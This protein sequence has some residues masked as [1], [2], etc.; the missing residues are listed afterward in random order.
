MK[1]TLWFAII[2]HIAVFSILSCN[3]EIK[4]KRE[5]ASWEYENTDWEN[6]GYASCAGNS[7]SPVN[8]PTLQTIISDNLPEVNYFHNDFEMKIVDNGHTIQVNNTQ[9]NVYIMYNDIRYKFRQ[10]HLHLKSEHQIDT[11]HS[12]MELHCVHQDEEGNLLV[13]G[14]MI[15][16]GEENDFLQT[17]LDHIPEKEKTE[18]ATSI[19]INLSDIKPTDNSYYTYSGSLTTPPCLAAVQFVIFKEKI[20]ASSDQIAYFSKFYNG[21]IRPIQPL[22]NRFILEKRN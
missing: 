3:R 16:A 2:I 13:L 21:N 18:I 15:E 1:R 5:T 4:I 22:N 20:Q 11:D 12:E 9:D 8:I 6:L 17:I 19:Q 14:Y 10:F 7:Q